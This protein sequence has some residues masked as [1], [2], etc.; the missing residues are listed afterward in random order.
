M[1]EDFAKKTVEDMAN[2][3]ATSN[4]ELERWTAI[5][6]F[7]GKK[8]LGAVRFRGNLIRRELLF[9]RY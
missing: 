1:A 7:V 2:I 3:Y 4:F 6:K 5:T 8:K 9:S